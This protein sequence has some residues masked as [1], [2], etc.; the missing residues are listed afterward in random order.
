MR[1][2]TAPAGKIHVFHASMDGHATWD[3]EPQGVVRNVTGFA[4]TSKSGPSTTL[5]SDTTMVSPSSNSNPGR[6][7]FFGW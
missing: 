6:E 2:G 3:V 4:A 7:H 5:L 1:I